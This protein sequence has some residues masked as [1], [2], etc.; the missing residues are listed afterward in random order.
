MSRAG[1]YLLMTLAA[2]ALIAA[3]LSAAPKKPQWAEHIVLPE[4][5][6]EQPD[7]DLDKLLAPEPAAPTAEGEPPKKPGTNDFPRLLQ[8]LK[9]GRSWGARL[10]A[11][12][13][14]YSLRARDPEV[15][16]KALVDA[17]INDPSEDVRG[18]V[19]KIIYGQRGNNQ[20]SPAMEEI[21]R[22]QLY[23]EDNTL[24][25]YLLVWFRYC[26]PDKPDFETSVLPM[27]R[28]LVK[29]GKGWENR[30]FGIEA[31]RISRQGQDAVKSPLYEGEIVKEIVQAL[32]GDP[33][34]RVRFCAA[35]A[36]YYFTNSIALHGLCETMLKD[37]DADLRGYAARML[38]I[39]LDPSPR[40]VWMT[41]FPDLA[42]HFAKQR[43]PV[44]ASVRDAVIGAMGKA[45]GDPDPFVRNYAALGLGRIR[46]SRGAAL[47]KEHG[48]D[49][50]TWVDETVR[51]SLRMIEHPDDSPP[52]GGGQGF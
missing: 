9:R 52:V 46:D 20:V 4:I 7:Q 5:G 12:N 1:A 23:V 38:G 45:L 50:E 22:R 51:Q 39:R 26:Q 36:L 2:I 14:L 32:R 44:D 13:Q 15:V 43:I 47:L 35:D 10:W 33:D 6:K 49:S 21:A 3:D 24:Y 34:P 42:D 19:G 25:K 31:I 30:W 41:R 48:A 40:F 27:L 28:D 8:E 29:N 16:D 18:P 17:M 11:A 37:R